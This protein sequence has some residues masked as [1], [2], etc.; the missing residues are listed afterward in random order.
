MQYLKKELSGEINFLHEDKHESLLQI[1]SII[2]I[3]MV[4]H[5]RS[6]QNSEFSMSL[7]YLKKVV[8]DKVDFFHADKFP[9]GL[10]QHFRH[11]NL[12]QG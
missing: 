3:G 7:Q 12:L 9:K 1:D 8:K 4:K 5:S 10:F 6:S 11:Q 2:L